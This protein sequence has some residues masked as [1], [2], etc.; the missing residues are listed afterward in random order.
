[1]TEFFQCS[2]C[3]TQKPIPKESLGTGYAT[4]KDQNKICYACCAIQDK[5]WMR[6]HG[7]ITLYLKQLPKPL[8]YSEAVGEITNWPGTLT[9]PVWKI[10]KSHHNIARY[11]Y[12]TWFLFEGYW[13]HGVQYGDNT[14][15]VHCKKTKEKSRNKTKIM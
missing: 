5:A 11:R 2:K 6:A 7:K 13:W 9:F 3:N 10:K 15:I 1:M 14:Q 12:D 4:D 8:S